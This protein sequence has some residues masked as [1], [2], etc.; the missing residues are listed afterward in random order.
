MYGLYTSNIIPIWDSKANV[1]I[2]AVLLLK[3]CTNTEFWETLTDEL[4]KQNKPREEKSQIGREKCQKRLNFIC[5]IKCVFIL[6][7]GYVYISFPFHIF[8]ELLDRKSHEYSMNT[9]HE[10]HELNMFTLIHTPNT[11][12]II[13]YTDLQICNE[14]TT[15]YTKLSNLTE[16]TFRAKILFR[17]KAL[18]K[19]QKF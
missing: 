17:I 9:I 14:C 11:L 4:K 1:P 13:I 15:H 18:K 8:E 3:S 16:P 6:C 19:F 5:I 2:K 12:L 7:M 10:Y